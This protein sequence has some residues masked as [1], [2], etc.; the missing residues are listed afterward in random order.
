MHTFV[1][2]YVHHDRSGGCL[3][4]L[5]VTTDFAART[6]EAKQAAD[7]AAMAAYGAGATTPRAASQAPHPRGGTVGD[8]LVGLAAMLGEPV[9]LIEV[10]TTLACEEMT[11]CAT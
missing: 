1:G 10:M 11:P 9:Y 2:S 7:L 4:R 6:P 8:A 3:V 5:S